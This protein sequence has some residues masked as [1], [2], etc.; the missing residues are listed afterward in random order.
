M[1][2]VLGGG[3][4]IGQLRK[5]EVSYGASAPCAHHGVPS[6]ER[7]TATILVT[8]VSTSSTDPMG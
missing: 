7:S 4:V 2:L 8:T 1:K 3:Q 5:E 6:T